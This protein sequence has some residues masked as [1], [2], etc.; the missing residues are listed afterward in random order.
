MNSAAF[1]LNKVRR[2]IKTQGRWSVIVRPSTNKFGEPDGDADVRNLLGVFHE[3]SSRMVYQVKSHS[4][5][6]TVRAKDAPMMLCLWED[7]K[8]LQHTDRLIMNNHTYIIGEI[9]NVEESNLVADISLEEVQT[10]GK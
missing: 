6:S 8:D 10:D 9:K 3:S 5:G 7:V 1:Q 4:D 2:L